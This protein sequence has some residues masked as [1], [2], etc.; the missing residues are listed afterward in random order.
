MMPFN[1]SGLGD[2]GTCDGHAALWPLANDGVDLAEG[3]ILVRKVLAEMSATA[4]AA[5]ERRA[6]DRFGH[7]QQVVKIQRG[8]PAGVVL[9]M[10]SRADA[11]RPL[12]QLLEAVERP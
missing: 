4:F 8:V 10:A 3:R 12:A 2:R 11:A 6:G 7:R 9:P 1:S 5:L